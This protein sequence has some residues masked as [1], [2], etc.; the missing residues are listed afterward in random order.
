MFAG[1]WLDG[2]VGGNYQ[3]H[4]INTGRAGK[5]VA[6]ESFVA[7]DVHKSETHAAFL[8]ECEAQIDSDAAALFFFEAIGMSAG[9]RL[10]QGG[11][12]MID[13][14]GGADN[15][16]FCLTYRGTPP[17]PDYSSTSR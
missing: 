15:D 17:S 11:F 9:E 5:H 1:R 8:Q 16:A 4:H 6:D 2:V 7:G 13:M 3:Q 10:H 12:A 14:T